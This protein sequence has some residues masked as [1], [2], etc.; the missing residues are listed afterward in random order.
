[1]I[2]ADAALIVVPYYNKPTQEGVYQHFAHLN[3][4]T[5]IPLIAYNV[6]GRTVIG[7]ESATYLRIAQLESVIACKHAVDSVSSL[8]S[9]SSICNKE[10]FSMMAGDDPIFYGSLC[11]GGTGVISASSNVIL[12]EMLEIYSSFT[13]GKQDAALAVQRSIAKAIELFFSETNP[14]PVKTALKAM[15]HISSDSVRLPLVATSEGLSNQL[16]EL[17]ASSDRDRKKA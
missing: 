5:K 4:I 14:A 3:A 2:G 7:V 17:F 10:E 8:V 11:H 6:P 16:Y 1:S 12:E 15:G 13:S 9:L